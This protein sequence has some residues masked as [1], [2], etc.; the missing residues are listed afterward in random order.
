MRYAGCLCFETPRSSKTHSANRFQARRCDCSFIF[1]F[2]VQTLVGELDVAWL[3]PPLRSEQHGN[4][5]QSLGPP[6]RSVPACSPLRRSTRFVALASPAPSPMHPSRCDLASIAAPLRGNSYLRKLL[7]HG[8]RSAV[9]IVKRE[10][11]PFGPWLDG[12]QR[13]APVGVVITAAA[14]RLARIAWAVLSSGQDH[15]PPVNALPA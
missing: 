7:V 14:N 1:T 8:A 5:V 13:R 10:R 4:P 9:L 11:S 15:R 6:M 2:P 3:M 12:L